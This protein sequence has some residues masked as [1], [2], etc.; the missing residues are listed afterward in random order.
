MSAN[1]Y[2]SPTPTKLYR[3]I[4]SVV[5]ALSNKNDSLD[6]DFAVSFRYNEAG[7]SNSEGKVKLRG[8]RFGG[9]GC[10]EVV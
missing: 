10:A 7:V 8:T 1:D 4:V 9:F 2:D 3:L 6:F 5:A